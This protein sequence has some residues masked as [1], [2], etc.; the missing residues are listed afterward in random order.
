VPKDYINP[1]FS[2]WRV[3]GMVL[4]DDWLR[5]NEELLSIIARSPYF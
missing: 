4:R 3:A 1:I 2:F 5:E